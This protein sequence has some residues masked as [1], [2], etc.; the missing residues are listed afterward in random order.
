MTKKS[1]QV[2][3]NLPVQIIKE[4]N[5]YVAYCP[6]LDI[7]TQGDTYAEAQQMFSELVRVFIDDLIERGTLEK[8]LLDLGW[9]K[10]SHSRRWELPER[11]FI[12][13]THQEINL[14]CPT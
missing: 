2:G 14:P 10:A 6:V 12:S 3:V 13:E 8:V 1:Y 9:K 7:A 11:Q 4:G 5:V